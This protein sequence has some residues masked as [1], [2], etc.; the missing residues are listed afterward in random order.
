MFSGRGPGPAQVLV[1][2]VEEVLVVGVGVDGGH[3]PAA[4]PEGVVEDLDHGHE[5]VGGARGVGHHHVAA[6]VEV[7]VVDAH[8][9][10]GVGVLRREPR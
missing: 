8:D 5:A 9:E 3:E 4:H 7:V 6:G 10:G 1:G 2:Q